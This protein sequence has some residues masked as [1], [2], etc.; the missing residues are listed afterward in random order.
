MGFL[1]VFRRAW[2]YDAAFIFWRAGLP[3]PPMAATAGSDEIDSTGE[4]LENGRQ[5]GFKI[6][7]NTII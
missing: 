7:F 4:R 5:D 6:G 3:G 1:L 2:R